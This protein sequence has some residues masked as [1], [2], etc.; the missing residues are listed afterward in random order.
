MRCTRKCSCR[1]PPTSDWLLLFCKS[2]HQMTFLSTNVISNVRQTSRSAVSVQFLQ[3]IYVSWM[4]WF[5]IVMRTWWWCLS[6]YSM[7]FMLILWWHFGVCGV[8]WDSAFR[9]WS[10]WSGFFQCILPKCILQIILRGISARYIINL[11]SVRNTRSATVMINARTGTFY[12][13]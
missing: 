7:N 6:W 11:Q 8:S 13:K 4:F 9:L 10:V 1:P 3:I 2:G 12:I 5:W